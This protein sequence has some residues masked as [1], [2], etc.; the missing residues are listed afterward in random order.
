[1]HLLSSPNLHNFETAVAPLRFSA[2]HADTLLQ[3]LANLAQAGTLAMSSKCSPFALSISDREAT[4]FDMEGSLRTSLSKNGSS[5]ATSE[6][7][8]VYERVRTLE[9][10]KRPQEERCGIPGLKGYSTLSASPI[11]ANAPKTTSQDIAVFDKTDTCLSKGPGTLPTLNH[12]L[13]P[14]VYIL[15]AAE[16]V[17]FNLLTQIVYSALYFEP[18]GSFRKCGS[19]QAALRP[20]TSNNGGQTPTTPRKRRLEGDGESNNGDDDNRQSENA[21]RSRLNKGELGRFERRFACL[22]CKRNL[23]YGDDARLMCAGWSN[24][25]IDNVLRVSCLL[26]TFGTLPA[27]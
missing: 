12:V 26:P 5:T 21:K 20:A 3:W 17:L 6:V 9:T 19:G 8:K 24:P 18:S 27:L 16:E 7:H 13:P 4:K 1:V 23:S 15:G 22:H 25:N 14:L 10:G 11:H 2:C